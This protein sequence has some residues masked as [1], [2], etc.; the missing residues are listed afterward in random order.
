MSEAKV[1]CDLLGGD[2]NIFAVVGTAAKA[3]RR[4][5]QA[6]K[7]KEMTNKVMSSGSYEQALGIVLQYVDQTPLEDDECEDDEGSN[8]W[9]GA[10][11]DDDGE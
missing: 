3:L 6:D 11:D 8:I 10:E 1:T 4:A 2:G 7:A 5:G 9:N